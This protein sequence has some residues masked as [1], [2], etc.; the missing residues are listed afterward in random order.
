MRY[1][2]LHHYKVLPFVSVR[3]KIR[4]AIFY[5][6]RPYKRRFKTTSLRCAKQGRVRSLATVAIITYQFSE[7]YT[8]ECKSRNIIFFFIPPWQNTIFSWH[9]ERKI[10]KVKRSLFGIIVVCLRILLTIFSPPNYDNKTEV[11]FGVT[12]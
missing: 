10:A 11:L 12:A 4:V 7:G 8:I 2:V 5:V 6:L 9:E 3:Q 1:E